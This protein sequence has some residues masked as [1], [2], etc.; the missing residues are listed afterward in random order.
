MTKTKRTLIKIT[1]LVL[2]ILFIACFLFVVNQGIWVDPKPDLKTN[3]TA[4]DVRT[5]EEDKISKLQ[6]A[7]WKGLRYLPDR[8]EWRFYALTGET[9]QIDLLLSYDLIKIYF[10]QAKGTLTYTWAATRVNI[11][12][13]GYVSTV[14]GTLK[15]D[16]LVEVS[17]AGDYVTPLGVDW[18]ACDTEFC[19]NAKTI[20]TLLILD[21]KGTGIS[22]GFIRYRW[23][24][25]SSPMYGFL[26]WQLRPVGEDQAAVMGD[27]TK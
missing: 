3:N 1:C 4:V 20:D 6:T 16:E 27:P 23:E 17:V 10:L 24:P 14:T 25:P 5:T 19:R 26:C 12:V 18:D 2:L 11:P 7:P 9:R 15:P 22:N 13:Q 8:R 21:D